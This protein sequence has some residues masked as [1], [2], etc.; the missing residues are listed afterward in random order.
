[1]RRFHSYGPVNP[2]FH[3]AAER[4]ELVEQCVA[5]LL[6]EPGEG[7]HFFTIWAARQVGKTWL[8][9]RAVEE[10]RARYG[11]QFAVGAL[12][13]EALVKEGEGEEV[14]FRSVPRMFLDG[15]SFEPAAPA[16]W[17]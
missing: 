16:S 6:G 15:F 1:M 4:R 11:D 3:F 7:G 9:R 10:I 12:S 2:K 8:K 13:M 17:D 5:Q 14:F